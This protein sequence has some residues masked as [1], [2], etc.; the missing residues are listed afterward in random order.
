MNP[1]NNRY[2]R[3]LPRNPVIPTYLTSLTRSLFLYSSISSPIECS[4]FSLPHCDYY[5][6]I[7]SHHHH[8]AIS[9]PTPKIYQT[10]SL[11]PLRSLWQPRSAA[12]G[13]PTAHRQI[14]LSRMQAALSTGTITRSPPAREP[15]CLLL[16]LRHP[17]SYERA[18]RTTHAIARPR[19]SNDAIIR[20]T[21][22]VLRLRARF[23]KWRGT[24][25]SSSL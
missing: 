24:R 16:Q 17:L 8:H 7:A 1:A 6:N 19:P 15:A 9:G 20:D 23:Q 3:R 22:P 2:R 11:P 25:R 5:V 18:T 12:R 10:L 21:I 4:P 13:P 14:F